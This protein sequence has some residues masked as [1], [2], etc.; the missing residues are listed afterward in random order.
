MPFRDLSS[1]VRGDKPSIS[2]PSIFPHLSKSAILTAS[3]WIEHGHAGLDE[4]LQR[5]RDGVGAVCAPIFA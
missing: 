5:D 4:L 3:A 1:I 2:T